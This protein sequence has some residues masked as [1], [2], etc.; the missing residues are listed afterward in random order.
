MK[1]FVICGST[2]SIG[3]QALDVISKHSESFCVKALTAYSSHELLFEQVR[4]FH[5]RI[6]GLVVE[7][8]TI[9]EDIR[10]SCEWFFGE[11]AVQRVILASNADGALISVVGFSGLTGVL[12]AIDCGMDVLLANKEPLVAAGEMVMEKARI[13]QVSILPVDSEHSAIFQCLQGAA[14][15]PLERILLTCSGGPFRTWEKEAILSA[16]KEDALRHPKWNMGQKITIDSSTLINKA[17]EVIEARWLFQVNPEQIEV[18][19]HPES[20][21]HSMI[22]FKDGAVLAQL[23]MP[24]MRIPIMYAMSYPARM[25]A[26]SPRIDFQTLSALHFEK[27][28]TERFPGL[29]LA[30]EALHSGGRMTTILNGANEVAV[31]AFLH[32]RIRFG[33]IVQ[34]VG[35]VMETVPNCTVKTIGDIFEAD[36][37]ARE[38]ANNWLKAHVL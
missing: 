38:A 25:N 34:L 36:R 35:D 15:N 1:S 29:L 37:M 30:Y 23:G 6:A 24:D 19:V 8:E 4:R 16:T 27:P 21:I 17:L 13:N 26:V 18:I 7:P 10:Y 5:P 33:N 11:D 32:D 22:E 14:G 2:G 20:I 9:P 28:D 31:D 3:R 12:T